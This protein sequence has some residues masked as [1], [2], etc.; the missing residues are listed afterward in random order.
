MLVLQMNK[1]KKLFEK[2]PLIPG[3]EAGLYE[4]QPEY[5]KE[6]LA[7]SLGAIHRRAQDQEENIRRG[8]HVNIRLS[9]A[10]LSELQKLSLRE[11]VPIKSMI[12]SIVHKYIAGEL[13]LPDYSPGGFAHELK[14]GSHPQGSLLNKATPKK[15]K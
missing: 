3:F 6:E 13:V 15:D 11:G 12:A 9:D 10:D 14:R 1:K 4:K 5:N 2:R 7:E 8:N